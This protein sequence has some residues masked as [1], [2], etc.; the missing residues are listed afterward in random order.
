M[1]IKVAV[2]NLS[3]A[4]G[5]VQ[6]VAGVSF[7]LRAGEI[8]GFLGPNGAGKTTTVES[9]IGLIAP[10]SGA[11]EICGI[12]AR[13]RPHEVRQKIGVA[14]QST[15]LQDKITPREALAAF[16]A[17]YR[18]PAD[19]KTLLDRFGLVPKADAAFETLS[20]G[21]RQR[22]ALALAF[23]NNPEVVFLDEPT[24]SL[25][26]QMRRE[27]HD[28]I[29]QM[30]QEGRSVLLTTHDMDEAEQLCDRI[31]VI[32]GGR[33][34]AEGAPRELIAG[35]QSAIS[36]SVQASAPLERNWLA[37]LPHVGEIACDGAG[38]RFTTTDL[39]RALSELTASLDAQRIQIIGLRAGKATLE[40]VILELT[41]SSPRE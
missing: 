21:Q 38:A 28:H 25:D 20:G 11:V 33:I 30:R 5:G 32:D 26:P 34:I 40:D 39:N 23:I 14:L 24:A 17:F 2:R 18:V 35:S 15:G 36:V 4:Y 29:R 10:D 19:P 27:L 9:V 6:A 16:G 31:A 3:K 37:H 8:F 13:S 41:G 1:P 22:L 12:D 7:E